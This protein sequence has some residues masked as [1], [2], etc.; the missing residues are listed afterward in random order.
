MKSRTLCLCT[1]IRCRLACQRTEVKVWTKGRRKRPWTTQASLAAHR[2]RSKQDRGRSPGA[3][4]AKRPALPPRPDLAGDALHS[5]RNER[6]HPSTGLLRRRC[7]PGAGRHHS[8]LHA[9]PQ[10]P[11][12]R[13]RRRRS[14]PRHRPS[15]SPDLRGG[16]GADGALPDCVDGRGLAVARGDHP[17]RPSSCPTCCP[18]CSSAPVTRPERHPRPH[19][20]AFPRAA[21][22]NTTAGS[23]MRA[24][25]RQE[26]SPRM[27]MRPNPRSA[28]LRAASSEP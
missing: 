3:S 18:T 15:A 9:R 17:G 20:Q 24:A 21:H 2:V 13:A 1:C 11:N 4:P 6:G 22:H 28:W 27:A 8:R 23:A 5:A 12:P 7:R 25:P 26:I 14:P 19:P 16:V 10:E